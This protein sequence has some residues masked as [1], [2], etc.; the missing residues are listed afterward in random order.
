MALECKLP[1][2][3]G[4]NPFF[5]HGLYSPWNLGLASVDALSASATYTVFGTWHVFWFCVVGSSFLTSLPR[6]FFAVIGDWFF[7]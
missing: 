1:V 5:Q 6:D 7:F 4:Y 2:P 3:P